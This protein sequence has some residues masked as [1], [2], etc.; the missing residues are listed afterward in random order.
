M[1]QPR[2]FDPVAIASPSEAERVYD[3]LSDVELVDFVA[4]RLPKLLWRIQ[5][6]PRCELC[7]REIIKQIQIRGE[8][9]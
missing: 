5:H 1:T 3:Q 9:G 4:A 7:R 8:S 6:R 2:L